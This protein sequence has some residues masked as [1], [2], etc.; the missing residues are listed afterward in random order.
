MPFL[1]DIARALHIAL[2][3][4]YTELVEYLACH[5]ELAAIATATLRHIDCALL[6]RRIRARSLVSVGLMDVICPPSTVFAAYNAIAAEKEIAVYPFSGHEVPSHH[7][8]L[9]LADFAREMR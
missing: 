3:P 8:E 7:E 1:C 6:A 5:V 2:E 9:R 4:P